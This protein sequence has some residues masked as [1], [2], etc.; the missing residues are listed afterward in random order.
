MEIAG[1]EMG[2]ERPSFADCLGQAKKTKVR[3]KNR[4]FRPGTD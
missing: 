3:K 2:R 1:K 4:W